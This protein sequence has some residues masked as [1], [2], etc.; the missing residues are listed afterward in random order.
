MKKFKAE[1]KKL[2]DLMVN[3]IYTHNEIFLRELISNA[4]D[5]LDK[6]YFKT[7]KEGL[8]GFNRE[9][10]FILIEVDKENRTLTVSDNG[11]GMSESD[12][13]NNLGVIA[14]SGSLDFKK[15]NGGDGGV[16]IIGQFGVGFYSSFMVASKVSVLSRRYDEEC[17]HLWES[18][19][20]EGYTVKSAEKPS[21]GTVITMK[22][23]E[24]TEEVSYDE[25]LD[26]HNLRH[27]VKRYSDYVR[28]PIKM[29]VTKTKRD[30]DKTELYT[31]LE[32][33]NSMTPVW[34]K[35][36]Q[37]LQEGELDS[38]YLERFRDFNPPLLT[39]STRAEGA[40]SYSALVFVPETVPFNYY[41]K[42][43]EKGLA[44]YHSG[45][46]IMEK[47]AELLPDWASFARGVVDTEDLSLN[48]SRELLQHNR[49]LVRIA[50][51]LEKKIKSELVT[52][53]AKDRERYEK[54]W[55]AFGLQIKFGAYANFGEK[56]DLLTDLILFYS[57][58]HKKLITLAEY[59]AEMSEDQKFI[60]YASGASTE[61]IASLPKVQTLTEKGYDVLL[62]TD[63]VDEFLTKILESYKEKPFKSASSGD[64]G[65]DGEDKS[66]DEGKKPLLDAVKEALGEEISEA[67]LSTVLGSHP[68]S[69]TSRGEV[70]IEMEK[71]LK[72]MPNMGAV[73]AEKVLE[74]NPSHAVFQTLEKLLSEDRE[75]F[76]LLVSVLYGHARLIEGLAVESPTALCDDVASLLSAL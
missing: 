25:F 58:R 52:L 72:N 13:E 7:G 31:E 56:K 73:S 19:G 71:V 67:R 4:S 23:K 75:K 59:S 16:N 48:I 29:N 55:K 32:T 3:S 1:S 39:I 2:L 9:D 64:L 61:S 12:L 35:S 22:I 28:Y 6:L 53:Q 65:I 21:C 36:K 40:V 10:F 15:E 51:N 54:F 46:M 45:V 42:D 41:S 8:S 49:Q 57:A 5:A 38:F 76:N 24:N 11:C 69:L 20:V 18:D 26:E 44:L 62:F 30:G 47:C 74:L 43:Y 50:S 68:V 70:S 17:A 60:Y 14:H 34:K 63:D 33:L 66:E 27:L 37:E